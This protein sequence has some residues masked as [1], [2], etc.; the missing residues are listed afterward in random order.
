MNHASRRR[1]VG[2]HLDYLLER[3]ALAV[4]LARCLSHAYI[5]QE[6]A[7][8]VKGNSVLSRKF[9]GTLVYNSHSFCPH[10]VFVRGLILEICDA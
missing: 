3:Y 6:S 5:L 2:K 10:P 1:I 7:E 4:C 8:R 9:I